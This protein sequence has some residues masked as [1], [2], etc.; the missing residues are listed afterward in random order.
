MLFQFSGKCPLLQYISYETGVSVSR[1]NRILNLFVGVT[2]R[3]EPVGELT[4]RFKSIIFFT[5]LRALMKK[6]RCLFHRNLLFRVVRKGHPVSQSDFF[7]ALSFLSAIQCSA[8][9]ARTGLKHSLQEMQVALWV[10]PDFQRRI[11]CGSRIS[12]RQ[13]DT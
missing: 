1:L 13:R 8:C 6:G 4:Q 7:F 3:Y 2:E 12:G 11:K 5:C 9:P 10:L